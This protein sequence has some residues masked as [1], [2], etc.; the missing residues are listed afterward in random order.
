MK[1]Q[2]I[3]TNEMTLRPFF[4][5]PAP[6]TTHN[7]TG[8]ASVSAFATTH[9]HKEVTMQ[10]QIT[11]RLMT[12]AFGRLLC[13]QFR[14]RQNHLRVGRL[15]MVGI[16]AVLCQLSLVA[17]D[18]FMYGINN[19]YAGN[20]YIY[21]MRKVN[22]INGP[23][24]EVLQTFSNNICGKYGVGIAQVGNYLY[25]TTAGSKAVYR[26]NIQ[27]GTN[28][29]GGCPSFDATES[30]GGL[31][32]VAYD[33]SHFWILDATS[34]KVLKYDASTYQYLGITQKLSMCSGC[35]AL[36]W[37]VD[38]TQTPR[39]IANRD[40][41]PSD[42]YDV[43]PL[44]G[45]NP[46]TIG[47]IQPYF[48]NEAGIVWDGTTLYTSAIYLGQVHG[49]DI[50]GKGTNAGF[51][52]FGWP[53]N[54]QPK[55]EALATS[56]HLSR[57]CVTPPSNMV[58]WYSFDQTGGFQYDLA[59]GN[60]A[61]AYGTTSVTGEVAN[62]L[63]FDGTDDYVEAPDQPWLNMGTG[64]LSI[65]AWVKI[66]NSAGLVVLVDKR[67]SG[68]IPDFA[69]RWGCPPFE[70]SRPSGYH[71]FLGNGRLGLQLADGA[72]YANYASTTAVPADN[73]WHLIAVTVVRT[74]HTG[75]IWYLDGHQIDQPF[76]PTGHT[77]SLNSDATLD[78]GVRQSGLGG[79]GFFN[80][81]LDELEIF[82][83][84]LSAAEV[85][86]LYQAGSAGKCKAP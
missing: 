86:S 60:T 51:G 76:D 52:I 57:T 58:A 9:D 27:T 2:T 15:V 14:L 25:Y 35:L 46:V 70:C 59:N 61:T 16:F 79:G 1:T 30:S 18:A 13:L 21:Q 23:A 55:V 6:K 26:I 62:A 64:N 45:G 83:R 67:Q 66:S 33:G 54:Y 3:R 71:F 20:I 81:G 29:A 69:R 85:L 34:S 19:D 75:G 73:Q 28:D 38:S 10:P 47:L 48:N 32:G 4:G 39:L 22:D 41:F 49:Y 8:A 68:G 50:S 7:P 77:G 5:R 36:G 56:F 40:D 53:Y 84:A 63:L 17:Q 74:S 11:T 82:N 24:G 31:G 37:F 43:Y 78:I 42:P 80:G 72:G 12:I 44:S 65:D